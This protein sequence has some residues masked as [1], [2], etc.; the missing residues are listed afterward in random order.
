MLNASRI[1]DVVE[2]EMERYFA[3]THGRIPHVMQ[4]PGRRTQS[5]MRKHQGECVVGCGDQKQEQTHG[6]LKMENLFYVVLYKLCFLFQNKPELL[7]EYYKK[8]SLI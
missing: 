8:N 7:A 2:V 1:R 5:V 3:Q 4:F 6:D